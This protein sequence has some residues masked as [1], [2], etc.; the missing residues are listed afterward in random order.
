VAAVRAETLAA[1]PTHRGRWPALTARAVADLA[2]LIELAMP[3]LAMG[4]WLVAW[5]GASVAGE[6]PAA[7]RAAEALGAAP[8][9]IVAAPIPGAADHRLAFVRKAAPTPPGY[10]RDPA[11]RRRRPW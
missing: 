11:A 9:E 4:G 3:L 5:K 7:R 10:P 8:P 1:D 6:L 2:G